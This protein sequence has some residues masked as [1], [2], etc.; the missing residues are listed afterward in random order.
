LIFKASLQ[1]ENKN[2]II[3]ASPEIKRRFRI[4]F[5]VG[6]KLQKS[7]L[8][9]RE[10]IVPSSH[11]FNKARSLSPKNFIGEINLHTS[12]PRKN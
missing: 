1:A 11:Y 4:F 12:K 10:L 2:K 7:P 6:F 5:E 8:K 3:I 9:P